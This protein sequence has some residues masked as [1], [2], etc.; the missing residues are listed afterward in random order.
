MIICLFNVVQNAK[1]NRRILY[2]VIQYKR[3]QQCHKVEN[4]SQK[5]NHPHL[6]IKCSRKTFLL[7][8]IFL[9]K[10]LHHKNLVSLF[11]FFLP[12]LLADD[13]DAG[14]R[15]I[16]YIKATKEDRLQ[17]GI[18]SDDFED[19]IILGIEHDYDINNSSE[20]N[21]SSSS[22]QQHPHKHHKRYSLNFWLLQTK[23]IIFIN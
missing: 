12:F 16:S 21:Q 10:A 20:Y 5:R 1:H 9:Q 19:E 4:H 8:F 15:R 3:K 23:F 2:I 22:H 13:E 17:A 14:L 18:D 11:Y 7:S 6:T